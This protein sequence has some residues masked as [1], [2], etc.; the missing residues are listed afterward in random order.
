MNL[1]LKG[2]HVIMTNIISI[3][4][5]A[6]K[7]RNLLKSLAEKVLERGRHAMTEQNLISAEELFRQAMEHYTR[8]EIPHARMQALEAL[9]DCYEKQGNLKQCRNLLGLLVEQN[10]ALGCHK[11][12]AENERK[13]AEILLTEKHIDAGFAMME[14]AAKRMEALGQDVHAAGIYVELG[15]LCRKD[16][17]RFEDAKGF[18]HKA[19]DLHAATNFDNT[20]HAYCHNVLGIVNEKLGNPAE[21]RKHYSQGA[22]IY[23]KLLDYKGSGICT[24]NIGHLHCKQNQPLQALFYFRKALILF[25]KQ[26][27]FVFE[28]ATHEAIGN[29]QLMLDNA[30]AAQEAWAKAVE[31]FEKAGEMQ[32]AKRLRTK[33]EFTQV[34]S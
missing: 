17:Q 34:G 2:L 33:C 18:Y 24:R 32:S 11:Q 31:L 14:S 26:N 30:E 4:P 28:G 23:L 16:L 13:L 15:D 10:L 27:L 25:G 19:T 22:T 5:S 9:F 1:L 12:A 3:I 29:T 8:L 20:Q 21:A 7:H 6:D